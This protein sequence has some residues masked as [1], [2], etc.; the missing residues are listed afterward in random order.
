MNLKLYRCWIMWG[1][2]LV[3][4]IP[5]I[6]SL[7][8]LGA[9]LQKKKLTDFQTNFCIIVT[10]L[11]TLGFAIK[12]VVVGVVNFPP[13]YQSAVTAFFCLSLGVNALVT[14]LIIYKIITIYKDIRARG[15]NTSNVQTSTN[16]NEQS[17][18]YPLT[19]M[20]LESGLIT[21]IG[22]LAQSIMY[23]TAGS[24][25][26]LIYGSIVMLYVR[27]FCRLLIWCR[28]FIYLL[29]RG[30]RRQL[31]LCASRWGSPMINIH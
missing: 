3:M 2:P 6:L 19:S 28:Y 14:A 24:G 30:F 13:W 26:L 15:F 18:L 10:T 7:A 5:C 20:L 1:Q 23:K 21:F 17:H 31:S 22:Q 11:T 12:Y 8:F 25:F 16:R 29:H 4:V 27:S 9:N